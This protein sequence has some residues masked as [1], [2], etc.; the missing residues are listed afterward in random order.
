MLTAGNSEGVE[1]KR[2][3]GAAAWAA[4]LLGSV[5]GAHAASPPTE[6][7][8]YERVTVHGK[9]LEGN[10]EGDSA[11][12]P[13]SIY[14]PPGYGKDPKRLFPVIY[15]LHGFTDSDSNWFGRSGQHFVN[16][17]QAADAAWAAGVSEFIL[18]MPNA[19]TKYQGSMYSNSAAVG[20]WE[21]FVARELVA[22]VD[23]HYRTIA[24]PA[25]RGL[26]GH[27]MG[28]YGTLRIAMKQPGVFSSIYA[29]S[30]CCLVPNPN[31]DPRMFESAARVRTDQ[32]I[33]AADF[34]TKA[35]LASAAA[36]SPNPHKPPLYI[37]LPL[38]DGRVAQ[39][40]VMLWNANMPTV[41]AH[42]YLPA[43]RSYKA[44]GLEA[45][46][47]DPVSAEGTKQL[48][49]LLENYS[50][51]HGYESYDGDHLNRIHER[52]TTK[53][54]PFFAAHLETRQR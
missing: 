11:D 15:L 19:F 24:K 21:T 23:A 46:E 14:L 49:A 31:S 37:D 13:V 51:A 29:M 36:W 38:R 17:P 6:A 12:R 7:G 3:P 54:L 48:H 5:I 27:S 26:A 34:F 33:A 30:S 45:G 52:I 1:M 10:L 25:S 40:I 44:I 50:I 47:K 53:L 41:M 4:V 20:D 8:R 43:L 28:G 35:M 9:S 16:V 39:D 42:Q 2:I 22:W 18:V 32:D